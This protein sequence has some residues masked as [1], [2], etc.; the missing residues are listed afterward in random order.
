MKQFNAYT[1]ADL[2]ELLFDNE[3]WLMKLAQLENTTGAA[4]Q[5]VLDARAMVGFIRNNLATKHLLVG[6]TTDEGVLIHRQRVEFAAIWLLLRIANVFIWTGQ[7]P[8][9]LKAYSPEVKQFSEAAFAF[10]S[11]GTQAYSQHILDNVLGIVLQVSLQN[12]VPSQFRV[13][14][15][16]TDSA[17]WT[18][19]LTEYTLVLTRKRD[20]LRGNVITSKVLPYR[21]KFA[22]VTS[23]L[24]AASWLDSMI[25]QVK[26]ELKAQ[27]EDP[28]WWPA[29]DVLSDVSDMTPAELRIY[30]ML[31]KMKSTLS[32]DDLRLFQ[33]HVAIVRPLPV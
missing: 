30:D 31:Q 29:A 25:S 18:P 28:Y 21:M 32:E 2:L 13:P 24:V 8:E 12:C 4:T 22:P 33:D 10:I 15:P 7:W 20:A 5:V 17:V 1:A 16:E 14:N 19:G 9:E 6:D 3:Q 27:V 23:L 11:C 26:D